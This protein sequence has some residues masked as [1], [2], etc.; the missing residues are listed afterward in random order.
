[1]RSRQGEVG[2]KSH[3]LVRKCCVAPELLLL[4][5]FFCKMYAC[6]LGFKKC[7]PTFA[8]S[9]GVLIEQED[10]VPSTSTGPRRKQADG[11]LKIQKVKGA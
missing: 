4:K 7:S 6:T 5:I 1:M 9:N 11:Q 10:N 3:Q 8:A 2:Q